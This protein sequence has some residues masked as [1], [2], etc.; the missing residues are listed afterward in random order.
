[1]G[2]AIGIDLGTTNSCI[3]VLNGGEAE[4]I[5]NA[6]GGRTT[7]SVVSFDSKAHEYV[8]APAKRQAVSNPEL[9]VSSVKR[10]MGRNVKEMQDVSFKQRLGMG[11]DGSV[12]IALGNKLVSP[13]QI[14]SRIL[15]KLKR[16]AEEV[17]GDEVTDLVVTVPAYF[18]NSQREATKSAAEMAGFNVLRIIN[19]PTA[20]ALAYGISDEQDQTILVFDLGGG[21]FDVSVLDIGDG[22]FDVRATSGDNFLGGDDFDERIAKWLLE[23]F[24]KESGGLDLT[25]NLVAMQRIYEASEKAKIELSGV[26]ETLITLPFLAANSNGPL[27]L[28]RTLTRPHFEVLIKDLLD[29]LVIPLLRAIDDARITPEQLDH[30]ILVGGMTRMP[31]VRAQV[32]STL[33]RRAINEVNPDEVVALGAAIQAGIIRG[34]ISDILLLDVTPLSLGIETKG[35]FFTK[36]IERNTT[37]PARYSEMFTTTIDNQEHVDIHVLQGESDL[38]TYNKSLGNFHLGDIPAASQGY[39][40]IEVT[41]DIDA[42]GMISVSALDKLTGNAKQI[43]IEGGA[44]LT[45]GEIDK[46]LQNASDHEDRAREMK[47]KYAAHEEADMVIKAIERASETHGS[48]FIGTGGI[49]LDRALNDLRKAVRDDEIPRIIREKIEGVSK[50]MHALSRNLAIDSSSLQMEIDEV[51]EI[52]ANLPEGLPT[53]SSANQNQVELGSGSEEEEIEVYDPS[54]DTTYDGGSEEAYDPLNDLFS[55]KHAKPTEAAEVEEN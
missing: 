14:S 10:L 7:P 45:R 13:Q 27:H 51:T 3:A 6:E 28:E 16:D 9:T 30:I 19:E 41:F 39:P 44:G 1:M 23:E 4:V 37:I 42:S 24:E 53:D 55:D 38:S 11:E 47:E 52:V 43:A 48:L 35:G 29:R 34:D 33:G 22:V 49:E 18:N 31:A 36:L 12:K 32:E 20:A 50:M 2:R 54:E 46:L 17:L 25:D 26:E 5:S 40:Q 15:L 21:T 8:G